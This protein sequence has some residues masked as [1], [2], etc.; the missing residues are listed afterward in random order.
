MFCF[1]FGFY[2]RIFFGIH[3]PSVH[4]TRCFH[5]DLDFIILAFRLKMF[6]SPLILVFLFGLPLCSLLH[7]S[8]ISFL[9]FQCLLPVFFFYSQ[10]LGSACKCRYCHSFI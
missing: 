10:N 9:Q 8:R 6:S 7:S 2:V 3:L 4:C 5:C 1:L